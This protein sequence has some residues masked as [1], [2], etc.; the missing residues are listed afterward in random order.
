MTKIINIVAGP[1][2]GKTTTAALMFG[3]MKLKNFNVEYIPEYT[4]ELV[5]FKDFELLRNQHYVATKQYKMFKALDGIVDYIV[6]DGSLLHGL[7]YNRYYKDNICD[8]EK[9]ENEILKFYNDFDNI[10]FFLER[11]DFAYET[12]GRYQNEEQAKIIDP[13]LKEILNSHN[14]QYKSIFGGL[15]NIGKGILDL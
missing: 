7:Y 6:T 1:G 13:I 4:K 14:I 3:L 8:I 2:A 10:V 11:G 12:A 9:T 15:D 5:W